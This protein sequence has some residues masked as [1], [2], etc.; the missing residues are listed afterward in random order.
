MG[1]RRLLRTLRIRLKTKGIP[2]KLITLAEHIKAVG[3]LGLDIDTA[4]AFF[5]AKLECKPEEFDIQAAQVLD[6][7]KCQLTDPATDT[8]IKGPGGAR[9]TVAVSRS[10]H[11]TRACK[12]PMYALPCQKQLAQHA[13]VGSRT[14]RC[15]G[16]VEGLTAV[17]ACM[18]LHNEVGVSK[19]KEVT[20]S[21]GTRTA[22]LKA[23]EAARNGDL[24]TAHR[25]WEHVADRKL[26]AT[27]MLLRFLAQDLCALHPH[28]LLPLTRQR[29][30]KSTAV[31][32]ASCSWPQKSLCEVW[33]AVSWC[34]LWRGCPGGSRIWT[35]TWSLPQTRVMRCSPRTTTLGSQ[36]GACTCR[37]TAPGRRH[38]CPSCPTTTSSPSQTT[39]MCWA[40]G[41]ASA[42]TCCGLGAHAV[43]FPQSEALSHAMRACKHILVPKTWPVSQ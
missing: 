9:L 26:A 1:N 27:L 13:H 35:S 23:S 28:P 5:I 40:R 18:Q 15:H 37:T 42:S 30:A 20:R 17:H 22:L 29:L 7:L 39:L 34:L 2:H 4:G 21:S 11:N 12:Q 38:Q 31:L 6:A 25:T 33:H 14:V 3:A 32:H 41:A 24:A 10:W 19:L 36:S 8:A 16:H 43:T